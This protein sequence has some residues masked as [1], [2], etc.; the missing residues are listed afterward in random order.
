MENYKAEENA[1]CSVLQLVTSSTYPSPG[2]Y[3]LL[4]AP[5]CP[6]PPNLLDV[7]VDGAEVW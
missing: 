7:E 3:P 4:P 1:A 5:P 6:L 2:A